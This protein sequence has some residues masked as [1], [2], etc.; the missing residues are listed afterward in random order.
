MEASPLGAPF[1]Y[2]DFD[3]TKLI[4]MIEVAPLTDKFQQLIL[5]RKQFQAFSKVLADQMPRCKDCHGFDILL[6][7][8]DTYTFTDIREWRPDAEVERLKQ[9]DDK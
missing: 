9:E 6:E 4:V 8:E 5:T 3:I 1:P 2:G 7:D